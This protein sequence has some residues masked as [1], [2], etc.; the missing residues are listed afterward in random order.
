MRKLISYIAIS[1]DGKIADAEGGFAWLEELPNPDKTDYG[2]AEFMETIDTT[3]M[4]NTT[5]QQVL[6]LIKPFPY[7]DKKNYVLTRNH[8]LKDDEYASFI[9]SNHAERIKELKE[10]DGKDIW[11]IGGG[12][13]NSLCLAAGLLDEMLLFIMPYAMGKGIPLFADLIHEQE[14]KLIN[15]K[16]YSSG[17]MELRYQVKQ[18]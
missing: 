4:G 9:S 5:Y 8:S 17:V 16:V 7:T 1:I 10:Q 2:Y 12:E 3:I 18:R 11:L 13:A 15:S 14:L 6:S